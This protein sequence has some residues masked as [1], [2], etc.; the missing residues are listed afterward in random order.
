LKFKSVSGEQKYTPSTMYQLLINGDMNA[1]E[2]YKQLDKDNISLEGLKQTKINQLKYITATK[3]YEG[4][5]SSITDNNGTAIQAGFDEKDQIN[6][7]QQKVEFLGDDTLTEVSWGTKNVGEI[8]LTRDEFMTLANESANHKW[9]KI[10]KYRDLRDQVDV[11]T[12]KET[13]ESIVW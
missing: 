11:A 7:T 3:I 13:V 1:D 12:D 10:N 5:T 6:F 8:L 2:Y 4:F 9:S